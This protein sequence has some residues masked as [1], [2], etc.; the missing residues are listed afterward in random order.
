MAP[1][2]A[3]PALGV[4]VSFCSVFAKDRLRF[5][6]GDP[7][8]SPL[9]PSIVF[10]DG[11][12]A[13][14]PM[15]DEPDW[16]P[17]GT[18]EYTA[19][20]YA[21]C[22]FNE[23]NRSGV[24][25]KAWGPEPTEIRYSYPDTSIHY[26]VT[27]ATFLDVFCKICAPTARKVRK[28][29]KENEDGEELWV[30]LVERM[31]E[32]LES[33][34]PELV[35]LA[36]DQFLTA[37]Q[38]WKDAIG[39]PRDIHAALSDFVPN[40]CNIFRLRGGA[41][42]KEYEEKLLEAGGEPVGLRYDL[43]LTGFMPEPCDDEDAAAEGLLFSGDRIPS[44]AGILA[45]LEMSYMG[46]KIDRASQVLGFDLREAA[47]A[48]QEAQAASPSASSDKDEQQQS[49]LTNGSGADVLAYLAGWAAYEKLCRDTPDIA[50]RARAVA[51]LDLGE[52]VALAVAGVFP[53]EVGLELVIARSRTI[54]DLSSVL[55]EQ[56]ACSVLGLPEERVTQL[57]GLARSLSAE[58]HVVC[59]ISTTLFPRGYVV[60]GTASSVA[61][62]RDL[63]VQASARQATLLPQ[64][65]A[66][67]T[68]LMHH[69]Q[70]PLQAKLREHDESLSPPR[71]DVYLNAGPGAC[72]KRGVVLPGLD[73][74]RSLKAVKFNV[75]AAL[76]ET[77]F[78][79]LRWDA[80]I[81]AMHDAGI[82]QFHECGPTKQ[83]KMFMKL[84]KKQA[85]GTMA[86]VVV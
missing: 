7:L 63:A 15:K 40:T 82:E 31:I 46:P 34:Y 2:A 80:V 56:A 28:Y 57:C 55:P 29:R 14:K 30:D 44:L 18:S 20:Y 6:D 67:H 62:F 1:S 3:S 54:A 24:E 86:N 85:F 19:L 51:G 16:E 50:Q 84:T 59:E 23:V 25:Y 74:L 73:R 33:D 69:L 53:F 38:P 9:E 48:A 8:C 81:Q 5:G 39:I 65:K 75:A 41:V 12:L 72:L 10:E 26:Q 4:D 45:L 36:L 35:P 49:V 83:L 11:V 42:A 22:K 21:L 47:Q 37:M 77:C 66:V 68:P 43:S 60:A 32:G 61:A 27:L 78:S 79:H 70:W 52:F 71:L 17:M 64:H 13:P 58:E 76:S